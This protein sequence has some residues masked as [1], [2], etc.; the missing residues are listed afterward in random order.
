MATMWAMMTMA[1]RLGGNK[2]GKGEGGKAMVTAM[3]VAGD[4]E[5]GEGGKAMAMATRMA[6]K[7][8]AMVMKKTMAMATRVAGKR[9]RWQQRG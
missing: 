5:E 3:R 9:R 2:E 4:D 7:W 1:M 6:G 8:T